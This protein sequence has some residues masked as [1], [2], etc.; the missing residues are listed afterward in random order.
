AIKI[1]S[2]F[3]MAREL[4][5]RLY[6]LRNDSGKALKEA[7]E[8]LKIDPNNLQ[9]HLVRSSSLLAIGENDKAR[10]ELNAI[11]RVFPQNVEARYQVGYLAWQSK[12]YKKAEQVFG[13]LY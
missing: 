5:A 9:G 6:L 3:V 10:D 11:T 12:D 1:R 7:E 2:D 13:E 4:Q 8:L